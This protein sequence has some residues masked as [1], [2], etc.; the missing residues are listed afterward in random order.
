MPPLNWKRAPAGDHAPAAAYREPAEPPARLNAPTMPGLAQTF[1]STGVL[2]ICPT[3]ELA[4]MTRIAAPM[5]SA[6][7]SPR[8]NRGTEVLSVS[9]L[10]SY[11]ARLS[12]ENEYLPSNDRAL[13]PIISPLRSPSPRERC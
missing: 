10:E 3:A 4:T 6:H 8:S 2:G 13:R 7:S 12:F 5:R 9:K 11:I 1:C